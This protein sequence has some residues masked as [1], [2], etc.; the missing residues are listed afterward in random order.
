VLLVAVGG[1][2]AEQGFAGG[3]Q[4]PFGA[5]VGRELVG[6][7][8]CGGIV[9]GQQPAK[10]A[11]AEQQHQGGQHHAPLGRA[12]GASKGHRGADRRP[13]GGA[14]ARPRGDPGGGVADAHLAGWAAVAWPSRKRVGLPALRV[15][16]P[17]SRGGGRV[18]GRHRGGRAGALG[19]AEK[20]PADG[21]RRQRAGRQQGEER[22]RCTYR[23]EC[24]FD[25]NLA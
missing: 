10:A 14:S 11:E 19:R 5:E 9:A 25:T 7:P 18:A 20:E 4:G 23:D 3:L 6:G 1:G 8:I 16:M 13:A 12:C 21:F 24:H 15:M 22:A 17:S 2:E